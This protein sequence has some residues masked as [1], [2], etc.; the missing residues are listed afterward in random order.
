VPII[1]SIGGDY[2]HS[3]PKRPQEQKFFGYFFSKK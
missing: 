1:A 2:R 3:R